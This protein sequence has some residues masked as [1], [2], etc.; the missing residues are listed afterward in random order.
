MCRCYWSNWFSSCSQKKNT[1]AIRE[2]LEETWVINK[3]STWIPVVWN[4]LVRIKSE[5]IV[6]VVLYAGW[7]WICGCGCLQ[8]NNH[9]PQ[10]RNFE[11]CRILHWMLSHS[12]LLPFTTT[13]TR[14]KW[15]FRSLNCSS[16]ACWDLCQALSKST[17][18]IF[19]QQSYITIYTTIH[20]KGV[21][22][23]TEASIYI[24]T[25]CGPVREASVYPGGPHVPEDYGHLH[26]AAEGLLLRPEKTHI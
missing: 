4:F 24:V 10:R 13:G 22:C 25:L 14:T 23:F 1:G 16:S 15:W 5:H 26:P 17:K 11:N 18:Q 6:L 8:V 19:R 20:E 2:V 12:P 3:P 9:P 21:Y 7:H